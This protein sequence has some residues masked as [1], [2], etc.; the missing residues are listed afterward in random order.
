MAMRTLLNT[1]IVRK[2][3]VAITGLALSGFVLSH[4][5]GNLLL[6]FGPQTYNEYSHKLTSTPLIYIAEAGLVVFF[7]VHVY[8]AVTLTLQNRKARPVAPGAIPSNHEKQARFGSR[9]MILTGL[10]IFVFL[11][12]H[13]ITFKYGTH[14][15]A[16]YDGVVMRDIHR[17]V[18]EKF[19]QPLYT[20]WYFLA[21]IILGVHLSHGFSAS[22]QSLGIFSVRQPVL[23]KIG[24]AFAL[25]VTGGFIS[26][27]IYAILVGGK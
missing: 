10:L 15:E 23:K 13:L 8:L 22:F 14:Y 16:T 4:M 12:L 3:L 7:L 6:F 17:L 9:S 19:N 2:Q 21:L 20:G 25:L 11:V 1:T 18:V 5:A 26:Q 24:W 27:P